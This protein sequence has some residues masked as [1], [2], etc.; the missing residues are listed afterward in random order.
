ME[1]A[2]ASVRTEGEVQIGG[3]PHCE[4]TASLEDSE[5]QVSAVFQLPSLWYFIIAS[6]AKILVLV[7][8]F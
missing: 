6:R 2:S 5:K 8:F 3:R 4:L 1:L 7:C